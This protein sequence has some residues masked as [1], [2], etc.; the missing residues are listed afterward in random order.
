MLKNPSDSIPWENIS[1]RPKVYKIYSESFKKDVLKA[2]ETM[3]N[4]Q[5]ATQYGINESNI[6]T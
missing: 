5:V 3:S 1:V 4:R 6:R 2:C